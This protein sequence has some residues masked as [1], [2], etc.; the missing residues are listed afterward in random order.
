MINRRQFLQ[1]TALCAAS[2]FIHFRDPAE[3]IT[4]N[5]D[6]SKGDDKTGVI[7]Y[8]STPSGDSHIW[9]RYAFNVDWP[10]NML[11]IWAAV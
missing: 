9:A 5:I 3:P 10:N 1:S 11:P 7:I 2:T 8:E 4:C 6:H